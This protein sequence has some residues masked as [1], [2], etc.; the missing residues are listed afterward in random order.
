MLSENCTQHTYFLRLLCD[1]LQQREVKD[2]NESGFLWTKCSA[3]LCS[4]AASVQC[5]FCGKFS[6]TMPVGEVHKYLTSTSG[7][8][9][10]KIKLWV[11]SSIRYVYSMYVKY[12]E[13]TQFNI[14]Q[15]LVFQHLSPPVLRPRPGSGWQ[16]RM[17][18]DL[19]GDKF[20][21]DEITEFIWWSL[22]AT[23]SGMALHN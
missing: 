21:C 8:S 15:C 16:S 20:L 9:V 4:G 17:L 19:S 13:S 1:A 2:V 12:G 23:Q 5:C 7:S 11:N 10:N 22:R 18:T 6:F 14:F 3:L